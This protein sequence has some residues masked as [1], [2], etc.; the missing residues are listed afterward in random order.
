[1]KLYFPLTLLYIKKQI[2]SGIQNAHLDA[3]AIIIYGSSI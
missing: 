2:L 1:M 3:R